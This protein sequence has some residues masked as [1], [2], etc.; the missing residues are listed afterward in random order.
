MRRAQPAAVVQF[1]AAHQPA[2]AA[3]TLQAYAE[4]GGHYA[5]RSPAEHQ[6]QA[7]EDA[8]EMTQALTSGVVDQTEVQ[9]IVSA[10]GSSAILQDI[11]HMLGAQERLF[12]QFVAE[13]LPEEP[14]LAHELERRVHNLSA[15]L[16]MA[17]TTAAMTQVV[18]QTGRPRPPAP[19]G[20]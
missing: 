3:L 18:Q 13:T 6:R 16:R 5:A 2:L 10:A 19:D 8:A 17:L 20:E 15:R 12:V 1:L 9:R 4:A 11:V 7:T 14:E